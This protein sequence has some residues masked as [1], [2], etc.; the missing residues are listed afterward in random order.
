MA[1]PV[2]DCVCGDHSWASLTRGWATLVSPEDRALLAASNWTAAVQSSR[3]DQIYAFRFQNGKAVRL[4]SL[5]MPLMGGQVVDHKNRN[6]TD[7]RRPNLR[8]ASYTQNL[9]NARPRKSKSGL[10]GASWQ[11]GSNK[12]RAQIKLATGKR[13]HLGLFSS[14]EAAHEAYAKAATEYFGEFARAA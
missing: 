12:W 14:K 5:I 13:L 4:H 7:N 8:P 9:Y 10:K 2:F 3:Q 11:A 1:R 6:G